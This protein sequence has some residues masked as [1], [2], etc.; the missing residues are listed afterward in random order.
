LFQVKAA[1]LLRSLT[2]ARLQLRLL[3]IS[4]PFDHDWLLG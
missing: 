3:A 2:I 4:A 1:A